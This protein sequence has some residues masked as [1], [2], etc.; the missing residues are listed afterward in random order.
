LTAGHAP[1]ATGSLGG[2][3]GRNGFAVALM[4]TVLLTSVSA[5]DTGDGRELQDH[6]VPYVPPTE[7]VESP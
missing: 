3:R 6:A 4:V 5:C 7:P 1:K 2:V